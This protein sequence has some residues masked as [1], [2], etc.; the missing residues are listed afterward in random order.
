[1]ATVSGCCAGWLPKSRTGFGVAT[2]SGCCAGW[3]HCTGL[4]L[5]FVVVGSFSDGCTAL[6]WLN[7]RC[8]SAGC[9]RLSE[10]AIGTAFPLAIGTAF[11]LA[12][13]PMIKTDFGLDWPA[14]GLTAFA[15]AGSPMLETCIEAVTFLVGVNG[16][17][18]SAAVICGGVET[19]VL[20]SAAV[21][22]GGV[23]FNQFSRLAEMPLKSPMM[24]QGHL[25]VCWQMGLIKKWL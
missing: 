12:G 11:A 6:G 13:P 9:L 25:I 10:A 18:A 16:V 17:I 7:S 3:L 24:Q 20:A 14:M 2:V 23:V 22:S 1:V 19:D 8:G 5:H 15:L 21:I 4:A